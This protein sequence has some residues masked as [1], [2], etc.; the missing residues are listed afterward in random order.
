MKSQQL[1]SGLR[2]RLAPLFKA[3]GF[4]R[5]TTML[6]WVRARGELYEGVWCQADQRGWD[7]YAGSKFV[8]EF[9][10][11]PEPVIGGKTICRRRIGK[12]LSPAEREEVRTVQN[13][14]I[15]SLRKPPKNYAVLNV[16]EEVSTLYLREFD[17]VDQPYSEGDDIWF[18]YACKE[19]VDRWAKFLVETLPNC[20]RQVET[21]DERTPRY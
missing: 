7:S 3:N 12:M 19:D 6:S 11:G 20:L 4:K 2:E 13:R 1:Y 16:C 17:L 21:W 10:L 14:I 18:R 5:A 8:V 9:Q 15:A